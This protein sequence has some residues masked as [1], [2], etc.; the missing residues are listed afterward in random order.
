MILVVSVDWHYR[1]K[2]RRHKSRRIFYGAF[3]SI[4]SHESAFRLVFRPHPKP[5]THESSHWNIRMIL[6]QNGSVSWRRESARK[7]L[8]TTSGAQ[9]AS[10][11]LVKLASSPSSDV[12]VL[13]RAKSSY[14]LFETGLRSHC[15]LRP[16]Q[17]ESRKKGYAVSK[18]SLDSCKW[19]LKQFKV[20]FAGSSLECSCKPRSQFLPPHSKVHGVHFC[21]PT[22][23]AL[24]AVELII[25]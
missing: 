2:P 15:G 4:F 16:R 23:K 22:K 14:Y 3:I 12:P 19:G 5:S 9:L 21:P 18:I 17:L 25:K 13:L 10:L 7:G 24:Q 8:N 11:P 1:E 6:Q 20:A